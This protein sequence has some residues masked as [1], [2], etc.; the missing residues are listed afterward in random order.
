[1][2]R[3]ASSFVRIMILILLLLSVFVIFG[4]SL[5]KLQIKDG[6]YYYQLAQQGSSVTVPVKSSRG[7]IVDRYGRSMVVNDSGFS[8]VLQKAYLPSS[9]QN[10]IILRLIRLLEQ[11][12]ETWNDTLPFPRPSLSPFWKARMP[13]WNRF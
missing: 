4:V 13:C 9:Q 12:G 8:L 2:K 6:E 7:E 3:I 1:M 10:E 11:E 5:A